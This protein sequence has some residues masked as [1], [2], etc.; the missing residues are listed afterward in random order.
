MEEIGYDIE[1]TAPG[2]VMNHNG[3]EIEKAVKEKC[4]KTFRYNIKTP[5]NTI[6]WKF[7]DVNIGK[8]NFI[9]LCNKITNFD[10]EIKV[11]SAISDRTKKYIDRLY[12]GED[13]KK[14]IKDYVDTFNNGNPLG[15]RLSYLQSF[16]C[17]NND[18]LIKHF[19]NYI[20]DNPR[21][22]EHLRGEFGSRLD[23]LIDVMNNKLPI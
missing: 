12:N 8:D 7:D 17:H 22:K 14:E 5:Y 20:D 15:C 4:P 23:D 2:H 9:S 13:I 3:Q 16:V 6:G 18:V 1:I 21:L 11:K 19:K 10:K